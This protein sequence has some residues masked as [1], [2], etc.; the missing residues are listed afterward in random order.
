MRQLDSLAGYDWSGIYVLD[1]TRLNLDAYVGAPTD[2]N[3]ISIGVGVCGTAIAENRNQVVTD[4]RKVDNY[5]LVASRP[6]LKSWC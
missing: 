2:H 1:G 6:G 4:V 3:Q 5:Q